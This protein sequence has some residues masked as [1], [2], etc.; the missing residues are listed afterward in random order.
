M[1]F[2]KDQLKVKISRM[3]LWTE[4]QAELEW[5]N[6]DKVLPVFVKNRVN[7]INNRKDSKISYVNTK[8]NPA[9]AA[10]KLSVA[11]VLSENK[12]W[13]HGPKWLNESRDKWFTGKE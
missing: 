9:D 2:V 7:E 12:L 4:S 11:E 6:S 5:S 1:E 10:T 8:E 13:W 3:Y